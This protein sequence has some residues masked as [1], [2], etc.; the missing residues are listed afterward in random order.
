MMEFTVVNEKN[1][2]A[3]QIS[4]IVYYYATDF[5]KTLCDQPDIVFIDRGDVR[6]Y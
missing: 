6:Q 1:D 4:L 3:E 2:G 5:D